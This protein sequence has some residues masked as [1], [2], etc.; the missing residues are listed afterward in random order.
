MGGEVG[1]G[2]TSFCSALTSGDA[3]LKG[4]VALQQGGV[5]YAE[6]EAW[7]QSGSL[8]SNILFG[9]SYDEEAFETVLDC[10]ELRA[11]ISELPDGEMTKVG[12]QG[13]R[14]SGGQRARV[15]MA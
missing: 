14:L 10:C 11:D 3:L 13:V 4:G 15:A 9:R 6:Q 12:E 5:A 1:A 2:K 7:M 8:K